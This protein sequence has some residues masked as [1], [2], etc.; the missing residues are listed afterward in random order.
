MRAFVPCSTLLGLMT[1]PAGARRQVVGVYDPQLLTPYAETLTAIGTIRALVVHG[2]GI[3][4][5]TING[6]TDIAEVKNGA[7]HRMTISPEDVGLTSSSLDSLHAESATESAN[8]IHQVFDG[9]KIPARDIVLL[10]AAAA[11]LV[12]DMA[13]DFTDGVTKAA[14]AIDS[15]GAKQKLQQCIDVAKS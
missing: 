6:E 14:A 5:L 9:A 3:D 10:N 13:D 2:N 4:E 8:I 1:N 11:L 12:A 7:V 15:G